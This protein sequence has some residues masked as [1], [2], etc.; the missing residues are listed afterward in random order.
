MTEFCP[1]KHSSI[2]HDRPSGGKNIKKKEKKW[3]FRVGD[4]T[5]SSAC[6]EHAEFIPPARKSRDQYISRTEL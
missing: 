3:A 4:W 1:V 2:G 6:C 5:W